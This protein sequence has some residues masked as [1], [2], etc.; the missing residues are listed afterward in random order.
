VQTVNGECKV[1][2][3]LEVNINLNE[4]ASAI[5]KEEIIEEEKDEIWAIPDF[6]NTEPFEFG[7]KE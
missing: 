5:K 4:L 6:E 3:E 1:K 2:I 7:K